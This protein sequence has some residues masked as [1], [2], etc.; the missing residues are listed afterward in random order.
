MPFS[1]IQ[2]L[3]NAVMATVRMFGSKERIP[4]ILR[5]ESEGGKKSSWYTK[6]RD[7]LFKA[8][9]RRQIENNLPSSEKAPAIGRV[10]LHDICDCALSWN[11]AEGCEYRFQ[12]VNGFYGVGRG[13]ES[14]YLYWAN[15]Y[16]DWDLNYLDIK[17]N[18]VKTGAL[19]HVFVAFI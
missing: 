3:S 10:L 6:C 17:W 2:Y 18:D 9:L 11:S 1:V 12:F 19:V 8:T 14:T 4:D 13:S 7:N 5:D 16:W 15:H